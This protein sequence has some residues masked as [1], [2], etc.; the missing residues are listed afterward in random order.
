MRKF[1]AAVIFGGA[2]QVGVAAGNLTYLSCPGIDERADDLL[3]IID[4]PNGTASLQSQKVGSGLNFT[5]PASFGPTEITWR[6][7]SRDFPQKFSVDRAKLV[8]KRETTSRMTGD[9][10][11]DKS[12]CSLVKAPSNNQI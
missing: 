2:C 3:V 7:D 12:A 5:A 10:Y 9:V 4:Q 6:S 1:V 11:T 8:L